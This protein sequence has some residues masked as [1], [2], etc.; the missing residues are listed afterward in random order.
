MACVLCFAAGKAMAE[1]EI[2]AITVDGSSVP[3]AGIV[4]VDV[5]VMAETDYSGDTAE[6]DLAKV[7]ELLGINDIESA[8]QYGVN[9]TTLEAISNDYATDVYDGWRDANGDLASWGSSDG[10]VCVKIN[11]ASSGLIDYIGCIDTAWEAG[12]TYT[13]LWGFVAGGKAA[14]VK[15][16]ISF[17]EPP[18]YA[19]SDLQIVGTTECTGEL[20]PGQNSVVECTVSAEGIATALGVT[21]DELYEMI[22]SETVIFGA[23]NDD[24]GL[25]VDSLELFSTTSGCVKRASEDGGGYAGDYTDECCLTSW[26]YGY[27]YEIY[28]FYLDPETDEISFYIYLGSENVAVGDVMYTNIYILNSTY[29]ATKA[30]VLKH[31]L[32]I[33]EMPSGGDPTTMTQVGGETIEIE[34]YVDNSYSVSYFYPNFTEAAEK[35][36]CDESDIDVFALASATSFT[37]NTTANNGGWWFTTEGFVGS[38]GS[39][40]VF[41]QP[42]SYYDYTELTIGQ[43]PGL[44]SEGDVYN[45]PIYLTYGDSYYLVTVQLTIIAK[46]AID[47]DN[48]ESVATYNLTIQQELDTS[49][50]F[51]DEVGIDMETIIDKIGTDD[52]T[53]LGTLSTEDAEDNGGLIYTEDYTCDP[54]P[55]FWLTTEGYV[56]SW[57]YDSYWGACFEIGNND[58]GVSQALFSC[59]QYPG[60]TAEGD[61]YKA[62]LYL[63]NRETSKMVTVN[64]TYQIGE[65][66]EYENVGSTSI[67]VPVS[68]DE[69]GVDFDLSDIAEA[70]G[71][72]IDEL[73]QSYCLCA[74]NGYTTTSTLSGGLEFDLDGLCVAPGSGAIM[75][76]FDSGQIITYGADLDEGKT[77][78]TDV[79]IQ[80]GSSRY[81]ITITF[82][83]ADDYAGVSA[84]AADK[85]SSSAVY[86]LSG[87]QVSKA[88]KGIYI[89][90]GKKYI[91]K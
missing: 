87:R 51:S 9:V 49:Y 70:L 30:Y 83:N 67:T 55:G 13:A 27:H 23:Y 17:V 82:M 52:P 45:L 20:F 14:I 2:T 72:D 47:Y 75:V 42:S 60:L 31:N 59:C 22:A 63:I 90:D 19:I 71:T 4:E 28:D 6:F 32:T 69:A 18:L 77:I 54:N 85:A 81:T 48:I 33:V 25:K 74:K 37:T 86:D 24:M 7:L 11:D 53:L 38:W 12:D 73:E 84:V 5:N 65:V 10:M 41:I 8:T 80:I 62:T 43:M 56:T 88:Q 35:L 89:Q 61:S 58:E 76:Y 21:D 16:V 1:D 78:Q 29:G 15:V 79:Y 91:V 46:T 50:A 66:T 64:L 40:P 36:G 68:E 57:G 34:Q 26:S 39:S 3:V 44:C